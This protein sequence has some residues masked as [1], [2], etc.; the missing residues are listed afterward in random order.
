V[1]SSEL[2]GIY[3][4]KRPASKIWDFNQMIVLELFLQCGF[5]YCLF[6]STDLLTPCWENGRPGVLKY[7]SHGEYEIVN[8]TLNSTYSFLGK[9]LREIVDVF[10]DNFI[11]LG[12]DE[13][14]HACW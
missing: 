10:P 6:L 8:P 5:F 12:M 7:N 9:F 13:A 3:Q 11:H 1:V 14:Y 4:Y 2:P